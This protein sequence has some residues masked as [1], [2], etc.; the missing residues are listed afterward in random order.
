M[1]RLL[2]AIYEFSLNLDETNQH[3][4]RASQSGK[5]FSRTIIALVGGA[6]GVVSIV[7]P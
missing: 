1:P 3:R 5:A 2:Y 7:G 6:Q 4:G